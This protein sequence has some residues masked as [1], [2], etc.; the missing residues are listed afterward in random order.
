MQDINHRLYNNYIFVVPCQQ[1]SRILS[2]VTC[3]AERRTRW[4]IKRVW[5]YELFRHMFLYGALY[6]KF[7]TKAMIC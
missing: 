1:V 2:V 4:N 5:I 7:N 3:D 6:S